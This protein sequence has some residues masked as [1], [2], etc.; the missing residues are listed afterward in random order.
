MINVF[1]PTYISKALDG[2]VFKIMYNVHFKTNGNVGKK[3]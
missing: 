1:Q 3:K 2:R